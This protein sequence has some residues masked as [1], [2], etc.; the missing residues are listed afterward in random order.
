[1]KDLAAGL[2]AAQAGDTVILRAGSYWQIAPLVSGAAGRPVTIRSYE[3]E[4]P[5]IASAGAVGISMD[6]K[7]YITIEGLS[8]SQV[9][10]FGHIY[11]CNNIL[12]RNC[13]FSGSIFSGTTGALKIARSTYC[14]VLNSSF[15][16]GA[17]DLLI[18]QDHA[19]RNI[20]DGNIFDT[21]RHGCASSEG[22]RV[23]QVK[24]LTG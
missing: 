21:A 16:Q 9:G 7:A 20:I 15:R 22:W 19:D 8:F 12:I 3:G 24:V 23:Q 4:K 17:S 14:K 13:S 6:N 5:T 1:M 2:S 10:G 11:D 18:L